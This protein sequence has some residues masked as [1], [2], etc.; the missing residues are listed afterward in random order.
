MSLWDWFRRSYWI[1]DRDMD[2]EATEGGL[3]EA[4]PESSLW[5]TEAQAGGPP[6]RVP[7]EIES[8]GLR[9][10]WLR[11]S[12]ST[13][14]GRLE[15]VLLERQALRTQVEQLLTERARWVTLIRRTM[16]DRDRWMGQAR[17]SAKPDP[18]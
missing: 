18:E 7:R 16:E 17:A 1:T 11:E 3:L 15:A 9:H 6:F 12:A 2:E 13:L 5:R 8:E 14:A 10:P 4:L